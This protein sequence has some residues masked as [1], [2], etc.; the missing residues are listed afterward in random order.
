MASDLN[1]AVRVGLQ[2]K[3][4]A[5]AKGV[6]AAGGKLARR[7][8]EAQ[9]ELAGAGQKAAKIG[10]YKALEKVLGKSAARM[11]AAKKETARLGRSERLTAKEVRAVRPAKR[12]G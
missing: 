3:F 4:T 12:G 5:S 8:E 1:L 2:D 11:D 7:L 9:K 10:G 6:A